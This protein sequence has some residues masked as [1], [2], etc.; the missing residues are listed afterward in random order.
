MRLHH[1]P[2]KNGFWS[3][4]VS[5]S[6]PKIRIECFKPF[7]MRI[8]AYTNDVVYFIMQ[9]KNSNGSIKLHT[10]N[11]EALFSPLPIYPFFD[12]AVAQVPAENARQKAQQTIRYARLATEL[13][14]TSKPI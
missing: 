4:T 6:S 9:R 12:S 10:L 8:E 1:T 13:D 11:H 5:K 3:S 14:S 7:K 2:L